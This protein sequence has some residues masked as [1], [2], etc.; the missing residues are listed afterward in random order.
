MFDPKLLSADIE[1]KLKSSFPSS[2]WEKQTLMIVDDY[3]SNLEALNA[4]FSTQYTVILKDNAKDAISYATEQNVDLI[5]LD[6]DMPVMDGYEACRVLKSNPL[7]A[8]IPIIFVTASQSADDEEKGL[9]LGAV[10][11][12][13]KPVNLSILRARVLNHMELVYYRKKL[14]V[15]SCIDG[16]TGTSNRRQLDIMLKQYCA[17]TLRSGNCLSL[18]MID[19]DDFKSYNDTYGHTKGDQ[20]LK[21]VAQTMMSVRRRETDIIGRYGGEE[22]AVILPETDAKGGLLIA[23]EILERIRSL[24]IE[25]L[26]SPVESI[27]T[28]SIGLATFI[29]EKDSPQEMNIEEFVHQADLQMYEAKTR[30]KNCINHVCLKTVETETI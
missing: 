16:L 15:L 20:C 26:G 7:T 17:S 11:Y 4:L 14:E 27:V 30:G 1:E 3:R 12:V 6:L 19:I 25:H 18:L 8:D 10:D 24:K 28:A 21:L 2:K 5:L 9:L 22:F 13:A 23:N 29:T